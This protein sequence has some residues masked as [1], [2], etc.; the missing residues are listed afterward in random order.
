LA[1]GHLSSFH[2]LEAAKYLPTSSTTIIDIEELVSHAERYNACPYYL[3]REGFDEASVIFAPYN[4]LIDKQSR[5]AQNIDVK[6]AIIIFDEAHNLEGSCG[7]ATSFEISSLDIAT[8]I[9]EVE[10]VKRILQYAG[11]EQEDLNEQLLDILKG[12]FQIGA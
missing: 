1:I 5:K 9:L 2:V 8:A 4:Y 7:D 12:K 11:L 3:S 10:G 6:D